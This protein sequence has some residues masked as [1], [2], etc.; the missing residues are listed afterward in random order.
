MQPLVSSISWLKNWVYWLYCLLTIMRRSGR[1]A[2][3][4]QAEFKSSLS[5]WFWTDLT[6][7]FMRLIW[8]GSNAASS[9]SSTEANLASPW[10]W[11]GY[12]LAVP[13]DTGGIL[14]DPGVALL[15][16]VSLFL[17]EATLW[18]GL[19]SAAFTFASFSSGAVELTGSPEGL[20]SGF[21]TFQ[22]DCL[23]CNI[24]KILNFN[25]VLVI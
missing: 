23:D 3:G 15:L 14:V 16:H 25:Q 21:G 4:P 9:L 22:V 5:S 17:A 8:F 13:V 19:V 2:P 1:G 20:S 11:A 10:C 6:N 7:P 12:W 18:V 24:V